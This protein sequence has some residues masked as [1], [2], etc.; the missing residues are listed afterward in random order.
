MNE[1]GASRTVDATSLADLPVLAERLLRDLSRLTSAR[2]RLDQM[3]VT[4]YLSSSQGRLAQIQ[5]AIRGDD[6]EEVRKQAHRWRG[7]SVSLGLTALTALLE[8]IEGSPDAAHQRSR[9]LDQ[10]AGLADEALA[11]YLSQT[12]L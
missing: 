3:L 7:A 4:S 2:G 5:D 9:E 10:A 1:H 11:G 6:T 8:I 12:G